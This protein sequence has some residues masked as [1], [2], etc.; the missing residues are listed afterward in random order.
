MS[1]NREELKAKYREEQ[2]L[3]VKREDLP[4]LEEGMNSISGKDLEDLL[5]KSYFIPRWAS[6]ENPEEVEIIPYPILR[7]THSNK[8]FCVKR[9]GGSNEK[10]LV[11]KL[12]LGI[13]GHVNPERQLKGM[14]LILASLK[15]ELEEELAFDSK[16]MHQ[17]VLQPIGLIRCMKTSV[18]L[19]HLGILF[20]I[21]LPDNAEGQ[22]AVR[23][24]D[25]LDGDFELIED[26]NKA[27][28]FEKLENWSKI[29]LPTLNLVK[30]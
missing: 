24:T 16:I 1:I 26:L 7:T 25:T 30:E 6:D 19:D 10:R 14:H 28:N 8:A 2:V 5:N 17:S 18:D 12:S 29:A 20:H 9:I 22:I 21:V 15:R 4:T 11:N 27:E 13:G 3:V 23:E